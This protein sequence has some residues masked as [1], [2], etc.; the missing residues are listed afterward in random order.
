M[1]RLLI[2]VLASSIAVGANALP[3]HSAADPA[4]P[5]KVQAAIA[6]AHPRLAYAPTRLPAN[7]HYISWRRGR[8]GFDIYF[9][10]RRSAEIGFHVNTFLCA[11]YGHPMRTFHENG[12]AVAWS[13]TYENQQAWR[14]IT[15]G[16]THIGIIA[17]AT[18]PG[19][20]ALTSRT[21]RKHART[22]VRLVAYARRIS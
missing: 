9:G 15:R 8:R 5:A 12:Q 19:D 3:A 18:I 10:R 13:A 2:A 4:V 11:A 1:R 22:L 16:T 20:D 21:R 7:Y 14:C 6:R 17:T